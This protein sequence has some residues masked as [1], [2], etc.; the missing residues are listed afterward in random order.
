MTRSGRFKSP[1]NLDELQPVS[2]SSDASPTAT[3]PT[4]S[5]PT[6]TSLNSQGGDSA[7]LSPHD[8]NPASPSAPVE[9]LSTTTARPAP[10]A[11]FQ[12][13]N[14]EIS[15]GSSSRNDGTSSSDTSG[16]DSSRPAGNSGTSPTAA[17]ESAAQHA[18]PLIPQSAVSRPELEGPSPTR[19]HSASPDPVLA[20]NQLALD[21]ASAARR[22][23]TISSRLYA[24][25]N[26]ALYDSWALF[27]DKAHG[28]LFQRP[29][30]FN[31]DHLLE[32]SHDARTVR[33]LA[34][35]TWMATPTTLFA[36]SP[37]RSRPTRYCTAWGI[38]SS[39]LLQRSHC[40]PT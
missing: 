32:A 8:A 1:I 11:W 18:L 38:L 6:P 36:S 16:R 22:G 28:Y 31:V 9:S 17:A 29:A 2:S 37:W 35:L 33:R 23:P 15:S 10:A 39:P 19:S 30:D 27:D 5:P 21:Y 7:P 26:T 24:L 14:G 34:T 40:C 4:V 25:V 3:S 12:P 20:W 13:S